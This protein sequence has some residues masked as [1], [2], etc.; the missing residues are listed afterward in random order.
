MLFAAKCYWPGVTEREIER[1]A[2]DAVREAEN[3]SRAGHG[4]TY[5]G[6]IVFPRD[7]LVLCIFESSSR[8]MVV[9]TAERAGIPCE[10]LMESFWLGANSPS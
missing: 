5:V 10:R 7:E 6:A 2:A 8:M 9:R 3:V 1:V 4:V